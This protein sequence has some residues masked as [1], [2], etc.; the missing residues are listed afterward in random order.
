[1]RIKTIGIMLMAVL[2]LTGCSKT[3]DELETSATLA[4]DDLS[5]TQGNFNKI[6]VDSLKNNSSAEDNSDVQIEQ[7]TIAKGENTEQEGE[8]ETTHKQ[9][10]VSYNSDDRIDREEQ[11]IIGNFEVDTYDI[12]EYQTYKASDKKSE[13]NIKDYDVDVRVLLFEVSEYTDELGGA[14]NS[15]CE[16]YLLDKSKLQTN[17]SVNRDDNNEYQIISVFDNKYKLY[18]AIN[19]S[20]KEIKYNIVER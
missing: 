6:Y 8:Q 13:F 7:E 14:L 2:S 5:Y 17:G 16:K 10:I 18:I 15:L 9:G 19:K 3:T 11:K 20:T 4:N 1:M 12:S